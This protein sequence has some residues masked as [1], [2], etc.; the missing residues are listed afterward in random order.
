MV[1]AEHLVFAKDG[2]HHLVERERRLAIVAERFLD[3]DARP[4]GLAPQAMLADRLDDRLV[5]GRWSRE[6]EEPVRVRTERE[7]ELVKRA[8]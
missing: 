6:V 1:D 5:S 4:S 2:V 8:S 3:D 7:V